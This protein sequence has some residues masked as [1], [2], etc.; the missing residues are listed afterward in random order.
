M[1]N[2]DPAWVLGSGLEGL[3]KRL[4]R[5]LARFLR[6][7][8]DIE[9]IAQE[10]IYRVLEA[11][12]RG[13]ILHPEA[14]LYRTA[15]NLAFNLLARKA[16]HCEQSLEELVDLDF[17]SGDLLPEDE[18]AAQNRFERFCEAA[19][20][21]PEQCRRVLILRKVYGLSQQEVAA[22]LGIAVSTVEKHLAKALMRCSEQLQSE[23]RTDPVRSGVQD[24]QG[25]PAP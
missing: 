21:L 3:R 5:Y 2:P 14:Y 23:E 20:Q 22:R 18:V 13:N 12:S 6:R 1:N 16:H 7:R 11:G 10:S 15:R 8:E 4:S 19:A 9:D 24:R 25:K 17:L